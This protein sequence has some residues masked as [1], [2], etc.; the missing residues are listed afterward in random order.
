VP[1]VAVQ[2][3]ARRVDVREPGRAR[4]AA[5]LGRAARGVEERL[6]ERADLCAADGVD[7]DV[8]R[9]DEVR[10]DLRVLRLTDNGDD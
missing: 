1:V 3:R 7:D 10:P 2:P 8:E 9:R 4:R 5:G 6:A